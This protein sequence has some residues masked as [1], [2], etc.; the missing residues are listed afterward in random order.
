[1]QI[2]L[3]S[4]L[5]LKETHINLMN[6][7]ITKVPILDVAVV[8]AEVAVATKEAVVLPKGVISKIIVNGTHGSLHKN[9]PASS[10]AV[11][12]KITSPET[13]S[14]MYGA[15]TARQKIMD[16]VHADGY[17]NPQTMV[18]SFHISLGGPL[19]NI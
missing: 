6:L 2:L 18:W 3:L 1:M 19:K 10:V 12:K 9:L 17:R 7:K 4:H 16:H 14:V 13:A 8:V 15:A 11:A 5:H